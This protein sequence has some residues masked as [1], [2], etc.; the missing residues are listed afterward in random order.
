MTLLYRKPGYELGDVIRWRGDLWR[1][2]NWTGEGAI[3]EK[4]ERRERTGAS[5]RDLENANVVSRIHE[6]QLI[7]AVSEDSSVAEFL[8]PSNWS[9]TAVRLPYEHIPGRKLLLARIDGEW[10]SLPRLGMDGE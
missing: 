2:S 6:F 8:D 1:P 9:M 4:V 10:V 3:L 5:W 7:E